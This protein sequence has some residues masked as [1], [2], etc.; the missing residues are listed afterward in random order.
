[1][2]DFNGKSSEDHNDES[3]IDYEIIDD[4]D[5]RDGGSDGRCGSNK[6]H[7]ERIVLFVVAALVILYRIMRCFN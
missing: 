1:M 6:N 2:R 4:N 5:R 7:P 3:Y